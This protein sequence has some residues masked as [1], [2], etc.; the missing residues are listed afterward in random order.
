MEYQIQNIKHKG[1]VYLSTYEKDRLIRKS[2]VY[3][4]AI[5]GAR[6]CVN[7]TKYLNSHRQHTVQELHNYATLITH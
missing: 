4:C 1:N 6:I 5:K 3:F 2:N 7:K